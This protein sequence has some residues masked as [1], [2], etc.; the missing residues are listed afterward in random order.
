MH[1]ID[2]ELGRLKPS[3]TNPR[4]RF[5]AAALSEL[6]GS[7]RSKGIISPLIVRPIPIEPIESSVL[8]PEMEAELTKQLYE[9]VAGERRSRAAKEAGLSVVP[10]IVRELS[11]ADAAEVQLVENLQREDLSDIEEAESYAAMLK[12]K[13]EKGEPRYTVPDLAERVGRAE[14]TIYKAL[15]LLNVPEVMRAALEAGEISASVA[16]LIG[17]IPSVKARERAA[18]AVLKPQY[19]ILPLTYVQTEELIRSEFSTPL[20]QAP[21]NTS[22]PNLVKEAGSCTACPKRSGNDPDCGGRMTN[23]CTDVECYRGK[24]AAEWK[25]WQHETTTADLSIE[26]LSPAESRKFLASGNNVRLGDVPPADVLAVKDGVAVETDLT[27]AKLTK[28]RGVK[29]YVARDEDGRE[30]SLLDLQQ[31]IAAARLNGH[32][33]LFRDPHAPR[34]KPKAVEDARDEWAE[35]EKAREAAVAVTQKVADAVFAELM[36]AANSGIKT[37]QFAAIVKSIC[38]YSVNSEASWERR[39]YKSEK[40]ED[41]AL[42][43]MTD[44]KLKIYL[45]DGALGTMVNHDGE[46]RPMVAPLCRAFGVNLKQIDKRIRREI[47]EKAK[48]PTAAQAVKKLAEGK[49]HPSGKAYPMTTG[50]C[51]GP[52][53][54][55]KDA[56]LARAHALALDGVSFQQIARN[57]RM[58]R[59]QVASWLKSKDIVEKPVAST[60]KAAAKLPAKKKSPAKA[61]KKGGVKKS[62]S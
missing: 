30:H 15:K 8:T 26:A 46:M 16:S 54:R 56:L 32:A 40:Q 22:D 45:L 13:D 4:K 17:R 33:E 24:V 51:E 41:A 36:D 43:A 52:L 3:P 5:N 55:T 53:A 62:N 61:Q 42:A 29:R 11:D 48:A 9:I 31:A 58:P 47:A 57:L 1:G 37:A 34:P 28:D 59:A 27:W 14:N 2:I 49:G 38:L 19:Q 18:Q 12:L 10:C 21:F 20:A 39:G 25:A 44:D 7:I 23:I 6:A 60:K 35:R 50:E